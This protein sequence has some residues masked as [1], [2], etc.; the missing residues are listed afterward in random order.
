MG[1]YGMAAPIRS[2]D[3]CTF[4]CI[5]QVRRARLTSIDEAGGRCFFRST[6]RF[7]NAR[8]RADELIKLKLDEIKPH[9]KETSSGGIRLRD[10]H[11][12]GVDPHP[13]NRW[14]YQTAWPHITATISAW[15]RIPTT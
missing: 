10:A 11:G 7:R 4:R 14:F 2:A 5:G 9:R 1:F 13:F 15:V 6:D 3:A 8:W 12:D